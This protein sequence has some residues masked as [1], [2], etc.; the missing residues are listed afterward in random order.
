MLFVF[1][2]IAWLTVGLFVLAACRTAAHKLRSPARAIERDAPTFTAPGLVVW[3]P[4]EPAR[5]H[6]FL[7]PAQRRRS[8]SFRGSLPPGS[9]L[10]R[11]GL[12][13]RGPRCAAGS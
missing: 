10:A 13:A 11:A 7:R 8:I 4:C 9:H 2:P 12:R 6:G 1:I 5:L 3:E